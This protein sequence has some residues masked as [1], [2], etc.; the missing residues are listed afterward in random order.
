MNHWSVAVDLVQFLASSTAQKIEFQS[1]YGKIW[2]RK[3][4]W[5]NKIEQADKAGFMIK[6]YNVDPGK[7]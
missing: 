4:D 5:N 2:N 6:D 7:W 3:R 1:K